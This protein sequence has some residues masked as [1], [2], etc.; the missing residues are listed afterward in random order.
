MAR[1]WPV[2]IALVA[3]SIAILM[4]TADLLR[5]YGMVRW[6]VVAQVPG[7]RKIGNLGT[8]PNMPT[9]RPRLLPTILAT[10]SIVRDFVHT[11]DRS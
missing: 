10:C 2:R 1:S 4:L 11:R 5:I 6:Y 8:E 9:G 3:E 7:S